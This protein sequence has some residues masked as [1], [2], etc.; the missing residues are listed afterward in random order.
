MININDTIIKLPIISVFLNCVSKKRKS[1]IKAI[2][3]VMYEIDEIL[4]AF[5]N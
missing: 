2:T 3:I 1:H 4:A 5:S